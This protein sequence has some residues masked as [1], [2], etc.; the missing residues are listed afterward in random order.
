MAFLWRNVT[1]WREEAEYK[2]SAPFTVRSLNFTGVVPSFLQKGRRTRNQQNGL[3]GK[4]SGT[5]TADGNRS[6]S[7]RG[8]H[9]NANSSTPNFNWSHTLSLQ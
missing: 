3:H 5:L 1:K 4:R 2:P 6:G 7:D 9:A 8:I